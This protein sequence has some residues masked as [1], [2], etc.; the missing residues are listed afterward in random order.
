MDYYYNQLYY[1]FYPEELNKDIINKTTIQ[2]DEIE[3]AI[4]NEIENE[5]NVEKEN[6][7]LIQNQIEKEIEIQ[8]N[9]K[10]FISVI[11]EL[12][13]YI[14]SGKKFEHIL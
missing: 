9:K 1:Y 13:N 14:K 2:S 12:N 5:I 10:K 6:E 3:I 4:Q 7:I 8:N 11:D